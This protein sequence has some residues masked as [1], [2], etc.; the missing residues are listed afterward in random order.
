MLYL[1]YK[2]NSSDGSSSG[3]GN[4]CPCLCVVIMNSTMN[5]YSTTT[6]RGTWLFSQCLYCAPFSE[7]SD[8]VFILF[9]YNNV[10]QELAI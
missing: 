1:R 8:V 10:P 3:G 9:P 2:R 4:V 6:P 5:C 7:K